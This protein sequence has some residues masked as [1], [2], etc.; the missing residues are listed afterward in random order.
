MNN[1]GF[2]VVA[3]RHGDQSKASFSFLAIFCNRWSRVQIKAVSA[4]AADAQSIPKYRPGSCRIRLSAGGR[5][6]LW[7]AAT[8]PRQPTG[9][10]S[11]YQGAQSLSH[12]RNFFTQPGNPLGLG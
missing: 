3:R 6:Q 12:Q 8:Q 7:L 4:N 9:A 1:A 11:F 2:G 10:L 5:F